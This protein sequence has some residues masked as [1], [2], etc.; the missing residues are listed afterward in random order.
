VTPE[1]YYAGH[2]IY[3]VLRCNGDRVDESTVETLDIA[4]D[5]EGRDVLTFKCPVCGQRHESL[6]FG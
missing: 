4:E 6:R 5:I 1:E 3:V 2:A